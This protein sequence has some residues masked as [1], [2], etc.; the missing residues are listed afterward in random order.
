MRVICPKIKFLKICFSYNSAQLRLTSPRQNH[1]GV[2]AKKRWAHE[3]EHLGS[4]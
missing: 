1:S 2:K 3:S 4:V